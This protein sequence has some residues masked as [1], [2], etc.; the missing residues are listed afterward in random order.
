[1]LAKPFEPPLVIGRVRELLA[2]GAKGGGDE[3]SDSVV[4]YHARARTQAKR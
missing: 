2:A 4:H 3:R 1:V